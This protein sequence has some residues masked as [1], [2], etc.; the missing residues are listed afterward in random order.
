MRYP[1]DILDQIRIRLR[2]SD[3]I[4]RRV[5]LKQRGR[6]FVGLSPFNQE[7]TPSF[8]VSDAKAFY[9]CFSSGKSGD[10]F[11]FL[12]EIDG[13]SFD[14]AVKKLAA[15]AGIALPELRPGD[16]AKQERHE[17]QRNEIT[18]ILTR[19]ARFYRQNL[20]S[21][22]ERD[23]K[24]RA[25]L[26][27]RG[28]DPATQADFALGYAP[29][30]RTALLDTLLGEGLKR[31]AIEAAG[32]IFTPTDGKGSIDRLRNRLVFP[33]NNDRDGLVGFGGRT[34]PGAS[35][36]AAK[37]LNS[38]E[39]SL[40][41]KK[42]LLYNYPRARACRARAGALLLVEG[43]LDVIALDQAGFSAVAPLG[44]ALSAEQIA[45]LWRLDPEPIICFDGDQAGR[46]AAARVIDVFMPLL[47]PGYSVRFVFLPEGSD[48]D[49]IIRETGADAFTALIDNAVPL[50]VFLGQRDDCDNPDLL[51]EQRAAAELRRQ[52]TIAKISDPL[53]RK[54][55]EDYLGSGSQR[56]DGATARSRQ[57]IRNRAED[58]PERREAYMILTLLSH[59]E[60]I[61]QEHERIA[62]F[63][64]TDKALDALRRVLLEAMD[65]PDTLDKAMLH[66]HLSKQGLN[67]LLNRLE[68]FR[69]KL[70]PQL[71]LHPEAAP[72][73]VRRGWGELCQRYYARIELPHNMDEAVSR[74]SKTD[75][76][77]P[78]INDLQSLKAEERFLSSRE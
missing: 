75:D 5:K 7:K 61:E 12:M 29:P 50:A 43:Y 21:A 23:P 45:L 31:E 17:K 18:A 69:R 35:P 38:P 39:T 72:D 16:R 41:H 11:S 28:L 56:R 53:T 32:L 9:H 77:T 59:P 60:L 54:Y 30:Q 10:I 26:D 37:Y 64:F 34:L 68:D 52:E 49:D 70:P 27:Q 55:Y 76:E 46:R 44:T 63:S 58:F 3:I 40:F 74:L 15:E 19:A 78:E 1:P 48:P 36:E 20:E 4:G 42:Q 67:P 71:H 6:E 47:K 13:L 2:V 51:P 66:E 25:Y 24:L 62:T 33:I 57:Q 8:T 22:R 65:K 73:D 14:E